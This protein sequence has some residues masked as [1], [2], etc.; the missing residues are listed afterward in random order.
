MSGSELQL[1]VV[2]VFVSALLQA[3]AATRDADRENQI[4]MLR[5]TEK[6]LLEE[7]KDLKAEARKKSDW[8]PPTKR[9]KL[10]SD[11]EALQRDLD[12]C[13]KDV[14][15]LKTAAEREK[16]KA[17]KALQTAKRA[18]EKAKKDAENAKKKRADAV[19][20]NNIWSVE[21]CSDLLEFTPGLTTFYRPSSDD[22]QQAYAT[23]AVAMIPFERGLYRQVI[24]LLDGGAALV[25]LVSNDGEKLALRAHQNSDPMA[26][27]TPVVVDMELTVT[28]EVDMDERKASIRSEGKEVEFENL[29][30][31]VWVACALAAHPV[32]ERE[33]ILMT[34]YHW[35]N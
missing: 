32:L 13:K 2:F 34:C 9:R 18:A 22:Q 24:H 5:Q 4:V 8:E 17:A 7:N 35:A 1:D 12:N 23:G 25:G 3:D 11:N 33:A 14:E 31:K 20:L 27:M 15:E 21:G 28:I 30:P 19:V 10:Q 16:S 26:H 29:P 6:R